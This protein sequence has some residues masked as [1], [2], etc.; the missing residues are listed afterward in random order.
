MFEDLGDNKMWVLLIIIV[1]VIA[2]AIMYMGKKKG[3][4]T[5]KPQ[6]LPAAEAVPEGPE[7]LAGT[8]VV[9]QTSE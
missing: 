5:A 8:G 9:E 7:S 2:L 1:I 3:S 6:A 4:T